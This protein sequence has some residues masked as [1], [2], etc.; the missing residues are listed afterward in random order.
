[1]LHRAR[2]PGGKGQRRAGL[3]ASEPRL[4]RMARL[5]ARCDVQ[6]CSMWW[7]SRADKLILI[8]ARSHYTRL[9]IWHC[10]VPTCGVLLHS[11]CPCQHALNALLYRD[12][13]TCEAPGMQVCP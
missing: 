6:S 7:L 5:P 8:C 4:P 12:L 13:T 2:H 10:C 3:G 1:M 9:R 11:S